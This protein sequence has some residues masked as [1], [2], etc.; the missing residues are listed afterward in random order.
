MLAKNPFPKMWKKQISRPEKC[1]LPR[2][3]VNSLDTRTEDQ[4]QSATLAG[5]YKNS[6]LFKS[7]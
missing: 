2:P 5:K 7:R 1:T 6:Y 3:T 4:D